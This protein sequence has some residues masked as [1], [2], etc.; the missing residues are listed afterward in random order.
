MLK[1]LEVVALFFYQWKYTIVSVVGLDPDK[2]LYPMICDDDGC[3]LVGWLS[4][5]VQEVV[6]RQ[7]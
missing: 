2:I 1:L 3:V 7:T 6:H 5:F 4:S